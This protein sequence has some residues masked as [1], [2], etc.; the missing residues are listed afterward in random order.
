MTTS[1]GVGGHVAC[2]HS[3]PRLRIKS[4]TNII[5]DDNEI[6][7]FWRMLAP[8]CCHKILRR[9]PSN[10]LIAVAVASPSPADIRHVNQVV[11]LGPTLR[12]A[13]SLSV[14]GEI[15]KSSAPIA[16]CRTKTLTMVDG[17]C[18]PSGNPM[19]RVAVSTNPF[20]SDPEIVIADDAHASENY[21]DRKAGTGRASPSVLHRR[22]LHAATLRLKSSV[23]NAS[24]TSS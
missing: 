15:R 2:S 11:V 22:G 3:T 20:F 24:S 9:A 19:N 10:R 16:R 23:S 4:I 1:L 21:A 6:I 8:S 18:A 13:R 14:F 5:A 17:R 7:L 12:Y